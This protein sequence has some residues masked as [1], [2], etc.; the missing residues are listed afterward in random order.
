MT[1]EQWVAVYFPNKFYVGRITKFNHDGNVIVRFHDQRPNDKF[2]YRK[3]VEEVDK[4]WIFYRD[5]KVFLEGKKSF[6]IKDMEILRK[7][8]AEF[9]K[10]CLCRAKVR[11]K[12]GVIVLAFNKRLLCTPK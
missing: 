11:C 7:K 3:D 9:R 12:G 1:L 6:V 8:Y 4:N 5:V 10:N 2:E